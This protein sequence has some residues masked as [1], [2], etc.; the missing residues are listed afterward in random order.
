MYCFGDL[1]S[2]NFKK[3]QKC[4]K[5]HLPMLTPPTSDLNIFT[6]TRGFFIQTKISVPRQCKFPAVPNRASHNCTKPIYADGSKPAT[7]PQ[8]LFQT[9][10]AHTDSCHTFANC[11]HEAY[12]NKYIQAPAD[13]ASHADMFGIPLL[14]KPPQITLNTTATDG[15]NNMLKICWR[16][17]S[18][19]KI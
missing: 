2:S 10:H 9:I 13:V 15:Q 14:P 19:D 3:Y 4:Q 8:T 11:Q 5:S 18:P 6:I 12:R 7:H 17:L 1:V 16:K